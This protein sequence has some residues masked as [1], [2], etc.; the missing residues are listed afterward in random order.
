M[1]DVKEMWYYLCHLSPMLRRYVR[2]IQELLPLHDLNHATLLLSY[3][4]APNRAVGHAW[5]LQLLEMGNLLREESRNWA[6]RP[7]AA[8]LHAHSAPRVY[9]QDLHQSTSNRTITFAILSDTLWN[10]T[11]FAITKLIPHF[12]RI[13]S[14]TLLLSRGCSPTPTAG[15]DTISDGNMPSAGI[16][17]FLAP[18]WE[19]AI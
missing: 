2:A 4:D 8:R 12:F 6:E 15:C 13:D 14:T 1:H 17:L 5:P 19:S 16:C 3:R 9:H 18:S 7:I 10:F 11:C